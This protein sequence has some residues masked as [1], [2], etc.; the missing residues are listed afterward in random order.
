MVLH[1]FF[2][3]AFKTKSLSILTSCTYVKL[4]SDGNYNGHC[5]ILCRRARPCRFRVQ[6]DLSKHVF[7]SG[8]GCYISNKGFPNLWNII[9]P[10]LLSLPFLY[11]ILH[12][13]LK[14]H[15][16]NYYFVIY[17]NRTNISF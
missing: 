11:Y 3:F 4:F 13:S 15:S 9:V 6:F 17:L 14:S 7:L 2:P 5:L 8:Q 16:F 12:Y 1:T 10:I